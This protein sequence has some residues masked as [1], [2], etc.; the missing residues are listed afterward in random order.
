MKNKMTV[1]YNFVI[2]EMMKNKM[3]AMKNKMTVSLYNFVL[4]EKMKNKMMMVM[5]NKKLLT[6]NK[7]T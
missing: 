7:T 3:M 6:A 4:F 2:F 1:S 5:K